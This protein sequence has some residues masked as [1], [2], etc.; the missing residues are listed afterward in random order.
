MHTQRVRGKGHGWISAVNGRL[1]AAF[2]GSYIAGASAGVTFLPLPLLL[3]CFVC[4]MAGWF[5]W[6]VRLCAAPTFFLGVVGLWLGSAA[7]IFH[8]RQEQRLWHTLPQNEAVVVLGEVVTEPVQQRGVWR[9]MLR[10]RYLHTELGRLTTRTY[11]WVEVPAALLDRLWA[12]EVLEM[13]GRLRV[14]RAED[15]YQASFVQYLRRRGIQRILRPYRLV[16]TS[17]TGWRVTLSRLRHQ[18]IL[19]LRRHLPSREGNLAAAIVLNERIGL[20]SRV[21]DS[22]R[23]TGTIHILSPSGT[24]VS[25]I[26]LAVWSVCQ[27]MRLPRRAAA[28]AV[29]A[30]IWLFAGVAAGGEPAFRAAVMGTLVTAAVALQ[31]EPDPPTALAL[32]GFLIVL[33]DTGALLDPGFQFSFTLVAALLAS[34]PWLSTVAF[35]G[36]GKVTRFGR[37]VLA[38]LL[39]STVCAVASAPLTALYYGQVSWIAP[40]ANLV[41]AL[42]V[43]VV[44][45]LGLLMACLPS[46]PELL[47]APIALCTWL[48]DRSVRGLASLEWASTATPAPSHGGILLFYTLLFSILLA[49][50]ARAA[51]RR[52]EEIWEHR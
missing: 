10:S 32:A 23:R 12:G 35:G 16:R 17:R 21:R 30:V 28:L 44:T 1:L 45:S 50:S 33:S 26:A 9:F 40:V 6:R 2:C 29:I 19:R 37:I 34:S 42:P 52:R 43:Q 51:Q 38:L 7:G 15:A 25:M 41:I 8:S 24:H 36:Q 13:E 48:V 3:A 22:F 39:A 5:C 31:R 27:Q 46:A 4:T 18:M 11:F 14:P 47:A 20:D 49:L